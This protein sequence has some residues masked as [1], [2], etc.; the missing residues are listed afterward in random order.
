MGRFEWLRGML[1]GAAL[2]A[3]GGGAAAQVAVDQISE[4]ELLLQQSGQQHSFEASQTYAAGAGGGS[5]GNVIDAMQA[6]ALNSMLLEQTGAGNILSVEQN[7]LR[8]N[9]EA[10]QNG[11]GLNATLSQLGDDNSI[12][13]DQRGVGV[14]P[15]VIDQSGSNLSADIQA[16]GEL[17]YTLRQT[18]DAPAGAAPI[19]V[20]QFT[21]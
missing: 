6:G 14:E 2:A 9:L 16:T 7:G 19:I 21:D 1:G 15:V 11:Q 18:G 3:L 5:P 10:S 13:L 8:N 17:G 12:L 4:N 20:R